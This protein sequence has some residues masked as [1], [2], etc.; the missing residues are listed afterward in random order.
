MSGADYYE[1]VV[2]AKGIPQFKSAAGGG[3]GHDGHGH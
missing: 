3:G 2:L 1:K